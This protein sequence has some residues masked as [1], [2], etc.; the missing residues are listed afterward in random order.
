MRRGQVNGGY[1]DYIKVAKGGASRY[2]IGGIII[3]A[4]LSSVSEISSA[5]Q[6]IQLE[7]IHSRQLRYKLKPKQERNSCNQHA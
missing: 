1:H 4:I 5:N 7:K 2:I 6:N 3:Q